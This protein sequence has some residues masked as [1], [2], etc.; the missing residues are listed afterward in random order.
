[1]DRK[2]GNSTEL[3][4]HIHWDRKPLIDRESFDTRSKAT[5]RALELA[6]PGEVFTIEECSATRSVC[7]PTPMHSKHLGSMGRSKVKANLNSRDM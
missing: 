6:K 2:N 5:K 1:M 4:F 7:G 3:H